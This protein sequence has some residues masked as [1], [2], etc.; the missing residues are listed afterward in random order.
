MTATS[1]RT[2]EKEGTLHQGT[3]KYEAQKAHQVR[4]LLK[5][6]TRLLLWKKERDVE[7]GG[8]A[9]A[10]CDAMWSVWRIAEKELSDY[11]TNAAN[12]GV[13]DDIKLAAQVGRALE[14]VTDLPGNCHTRHIA[15]TGPLE[16][17]D[18]KPNFHGRSSYFFSPA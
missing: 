5:G 11:Q 16:L 9:T 10:E 8:G 3:A 15:I 18:K 4:T 17:W 13:D 2:P 7:G 14:M 1:P 6:A 12:E